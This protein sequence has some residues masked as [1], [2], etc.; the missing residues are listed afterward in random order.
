MDKKYKIKLNLIIKLN[1][2][3]VIIILVNLRKLHKILMYHLT[4]L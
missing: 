2:N 3:F 1:K 4:N